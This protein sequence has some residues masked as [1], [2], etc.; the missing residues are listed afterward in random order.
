MMFSVL[1]YVPSIEVL[2]FA[3]STL[4]EL[5]GTIRAGVLDFTTLRDD[6]RLF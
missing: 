2:R 3:D 6:A 5:S 4:T 1:I